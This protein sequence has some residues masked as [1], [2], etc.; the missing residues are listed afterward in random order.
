MGEEMVDTRTPLW[1]GVHPAAHIHD[2]AT[3]GPD[4]AVGPGAVVGPGVVVGARTTIGSNALIERDT[5]LG[6]DCVIA[7]GAV[8]GTDP[9]DLK[10]GGEETQLV[11]GARTVIREYATLNR[12]TS[13]S[14]RTSV[15]SDCL[16]M[17]YTHVAH[18]CQIGDR[19]VLANAVNMG[20]HVTIGDW[21][22][23]GGMTP[24]HQFVRIGTHAF[25][26]GAS[27]VHK[28]VPPYV[29]A[30]GNPME[31]SGLNGVGLRRR[32]FG[33]EVRR[34]LKRAYRLIYGSPLNLTQALA[35][36]REE[37]EPLPEVQTFLDFFE[38]SERGVAL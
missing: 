12:G 17:A 28:D 8:L 24:I 13:A 5:I 25:V 11:V 32:G 38:G 2:D 14:G 36:A 21:A 31:M 4:V 33:P 6:E 22:I 18:D 34:E 29:R 3:L 27:R 37:L 20:G 7:H 10:F 26:G 30:A 15:G 23:V 16:I 1:T 9:Q 19:V 35:R